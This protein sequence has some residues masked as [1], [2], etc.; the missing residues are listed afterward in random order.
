MKKRTLIS[1]LLILVIVISGCSVKTK[2]E[3]PCGDRN[4]RIQQKLHKNRLDIELLAKSSSENDVNIVRDQL[5]K[6]GFNVKLN[7]QPDYGSFKSQQ[8]AGNYDI[9]L[10]SWTTVTGNPGLCRYVPFSKQVEITVF[11]QMGSS[12]NSLMQEATQTPDEYK[13]T[14]KQF[15]RPL[16]NGS[17]LYRSIVHFPEKSGR[18]SETFSECRTRFACPNPAPWLGN[19]LSSRTAPKCQRSVDSDAKCI[20]TDFS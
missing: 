17:G 14:Y 4:Q 3:S 2:T 1:L 5:T 8:D 15:G 20:R 10:S 13:D 11:L 9:A 7:L 6:N 12:I 18:E 19:R 16:G